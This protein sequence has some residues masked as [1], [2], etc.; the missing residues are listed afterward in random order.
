MKYENQTSLKILNYRG[1]LKI[2]T[3]AYNM[4]KENYKSQDLYF[5]Q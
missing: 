1:Y 2:L 4:K 5:D 3:T